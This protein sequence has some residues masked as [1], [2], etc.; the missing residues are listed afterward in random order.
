LRPPLRVAARPEVA[1]RRPLRRDTVEDAGARLEDE[2]AVRSRADCTDA[3][4]RLF[5]AQRPRADAADSGAEGAGGGQ[6]VAAEGHVRADQVADART[7]DGHPA[8]GAPDDPVELGREARGPPAL[9]RRL[10]GAADAEHER[11]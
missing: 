5:A 11:I 6:N 8:V 3:Q 4:L 1:V 9:P 7:F 2:D 10:G